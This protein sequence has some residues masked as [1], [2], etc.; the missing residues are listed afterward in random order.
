VAVSDLRDKR[1]ICLSTIDWDF[2]RQGHQEIMSRFAASGYDVTFVENLGGVR[3]IRLSD[4]ARV[5]RRFR[6]WSARGRPHDLG[7]TPGVTV[8]SPL[9]L[10][11]P[12]NRLAQQINRFLLRGLGRRLTRETDDPIIFTYLPTHEANQLIDQ[13]RGRHSVVVYY[14]VAD[15]AQLADDS[16]ALAQSESELVRS[17][18]LVFVQSKRFKERFAA[19]NERIF[20]FPGGVDLK[21]FDPSRV[22]RVPAEL[23]DLPRPLLGYVGG[24]HQHLNFG[25]LRRLAREL[26]QASIILIGPALTSVFELQTESNLHLLGLRPMEALPAYI[27]AFD[28]ALIP[29]L[30]TEYTRTVFPSKMLEYLAMGRPVVST[31]LPEI[32]NLDLPSSIVRLE[33]TMDGFVRAVRESMTAQDSQTAELRREAVRRFDWGTVVGEMGTLITQTLDRKL[34]VAHRPPR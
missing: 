32:R 10:P 25:L 3:T 14:C 20:D 4:A 31:D 11:F 24:L 22:H 21:L 23:R 18:D 34:E 28:A 2:L 7:V 5:L 15:F 12:R 30:D 26:S 16:A 33:A 8:V 9:L 13:V 29:Y 6:H 17:A 27:Q 19:L 1:L